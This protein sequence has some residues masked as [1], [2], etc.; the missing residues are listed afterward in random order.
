M[1]A[2]PKEFSKIILAL[3][4]AKLGSHGWAARKP[5]MFSLDLSTDVYGWIGLNKAVGRG[6]EILEINPIVGV[7][8]HKMERLVM[9]LLGQKFQPYVGI[10]IGKNV[11]YLS[12]EKK[13]KP[14]LFHAG[15]NP[16]PLV[17][18]MVANIQTFGLPYI[19][20]HVQLSILGQAVRDMGG[21]LDKYHI[22]ATYVLLG[23]NGEAEKFLVA[24]LDKIGDRTDADANLFR[25]F[26]SKLRTRYVKILETEI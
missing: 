11:G 8:S 21:P 7:G 12:P 25:N 3:V 5:G 19:Q 6:R 24:T 13:Y 10:A 16:E 15:E 20:A 26:A 14:W 22:P 23:E 17:A 4:G 18:D 1:M 9:E 2:A